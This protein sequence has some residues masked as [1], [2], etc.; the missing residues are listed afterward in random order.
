[1]LFDNMSKDELREY[2]DFLLWHYRVVD[3]FWYILIDQEQGEERANHFNERVWDRVAG[4]AARD[5]KQRYD[6]KDTGLKGF[7]QALK[8]FPW[9]IIV[10]YTI[11][12]RPDEVVITVPE[13]P[14]QVARL[15][16]NLGEY[17]CKQMH[18]GEFKAFAREIDPAI[19][20]HCIH[21][22]LD[23]HPPTHFCQWRFT[24]AGND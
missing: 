19:E 12:E 1:M 24:V 11:E 13:C 5:L 8:L 9:A 4:L 6:I 15:K 17:A 23:P 18:M 16:R 20:V 2:L 10:G 21:A 22:P 3:S 14:T 7:V